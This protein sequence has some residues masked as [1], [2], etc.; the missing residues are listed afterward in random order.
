MET[1]SALL[2]LCAGNSPVTV[3]FPAQRPVTRILD[4][5]FLSAPQQT[6]V[7]TS[8]TLVILDAIAPIMTSLLW[9]NMS[10]AARLLVMHNGILY[11]CRWPKPN[12]LISWNPA[13]PQIENV[14]WCRMVAGC[15]RS[16]CCLQ[17]ASTNCGHVTPYKACIWASI[18]SGKGMLSYST[19]PLPEP[20][21]LTHHQ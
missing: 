11:K 21:A 20:M 12:F 1:F 18:G 7:Q 16:K 4:V 10:K 5:F 2:T 14:L 17:Q 15:L 9:S 13:K 6:V 3:E 19:N 8:E